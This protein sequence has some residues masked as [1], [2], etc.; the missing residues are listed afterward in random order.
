MSSCSVKSN[1]FFLSEKGS[2]LFLESLEKIYTI[3]C[4]LLSLNKDL[5]IEDRSEFSSL[6]SEFDITVNNASLNGPDS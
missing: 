5:N 2:N 4:E 3:L 6:A 1:L